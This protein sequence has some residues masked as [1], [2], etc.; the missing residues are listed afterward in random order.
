MTSPPIDPRAILQALCERGVDFIVVGGVAAVL[1]GVPLTTL[2]LDIVY[3]AEPDDVDR[4]VAALQSLDAIYRDLAARRVAPTAWHLAAA[5]HNLLNTRLGPLDVLGYVGTPGAER[6]YPDL[7]PLTVEMDIGEGL[8]VRVL[9]L[10][11]L[12]TT[13]Q[14][15]NR[16]KDRVVLPLL[17]HT[18][19]EKQRLKG[20]AS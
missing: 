19:E 9:D 6:R 11:T 8:Q 1:H 10:P 14:E 13:K 18:L 16:D 3:S 12:I 2:D 4:L 15:A 20:D 5:G 7:L 17:R